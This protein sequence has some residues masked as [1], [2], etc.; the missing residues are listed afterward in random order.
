MWRFQYLLGIPT[1]LHVASALAFYLLAI[2]T[3]VGLVAW[4]GARVLEA[5]THTASRAAGLDDAVAA[6]DDAIEE[7][8]AVG[9][10]S[11]GDWPR[12]ASGAAAPVMPAKVPM[13]G[14]GSALAVIDEATRAGGDA[15]DATSFYRGRGGTY[16]T[17]C[18]RLCDGYHWPISFSTTEDFFGR[19][20]EACQ[21]SCGMP[22]RLYV[23]PTPSGNADNM[24]SLSGQPYSRL[25]TA[26]QFRARYD[27]ACT[28]NGQPWERA[29]LERHQGY[30]VEA[31]GDKAEREAVA[32]TKGSRKAREQAGEVAR[33]EAEAAA[34]ARFAAMSVA[35]P[36]P[37]PADDA[38][39]PAPL[40]ASGSD[41]IE[42]A[43]PLPVAMSEAER[44]RLAQV[45]SEME[46]AM[47]LGGPKDGESSRRVA[48][49]SYRS[50]PAPVWELKAFSGN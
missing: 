25:R 23:M 9:E 11:G 37:L 41:R 17:V 8:T 24:T 4:S 21:R 30:A 33:S 34:S 19:D 43:A 5:L 29:S 38:K 46:D 13:S 1:R 36:T 2:A 3:I 39:S 49:P 20:E 44:E 42:P 45:R 14:A 26:Y 16:R 48:S 10:A 27:A 40:L 50:S 18:V 22:A 12:T 47:S 6:L 15:T 7:L 35:P 28:C 31:A 32:A